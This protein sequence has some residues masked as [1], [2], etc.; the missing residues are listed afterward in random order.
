MLFHF[1]HHFCHVHLLVSNSNRH[2]TT[3]NADR[4][5]ERDVNDLSYSRVECCYAAPPQSG[6]FDKQD[7]LTCQWLLSNA[8]LMSD[9]NEI[10]KNK[11]DILNTQYL[12]Q[13]LRKVT[14]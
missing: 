13:A 9:I 2:P 12:F 6:H 3:L 5:R 11:T 4:R 1:V 8:N 10:K 14:Q 7:P